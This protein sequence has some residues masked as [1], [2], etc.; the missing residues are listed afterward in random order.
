MVGVIVGVWVDVGSGVG[1]GINVGVIGNG[2]T[3]P[4][5]I[6]GVNS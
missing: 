2:G 3:G 1:N 5:T 6:G 4:S